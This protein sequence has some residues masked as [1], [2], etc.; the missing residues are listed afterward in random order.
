MM[1]LPYR[2]RRKRTDNAEMPFGNLKPKHEKWMKNEWKTETH[3]KQTRRL[4]L[5]DGVFRVIFHVVLNNRLPFLIRFSSHFT[6]C[7]SENGI[8]NRQRNNM[9]N[10][11]KNV[12]FQKQVAC[13]ILMFF[14]FPSIFHPFFVFWFQLA[15]G[16]F[17]I[18][19]SFCSLSIWQLHHSIHPTEQAKKI[20]I[21]HC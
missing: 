20:K 8:K 5:K 9:K 3:Q 21:K 10:D 18:V 7:F 2:E 6:F 1:Q 11:P 15:K 19:R 4:F 17:G 14:Y 12:I 16:H 13:P